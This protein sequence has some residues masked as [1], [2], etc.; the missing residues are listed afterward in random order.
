MTFFSIIIPTYNRAHLLPRCL[1]S[2]LAQSLADFEVIV[3]DDGS[4]DGTRTLVA[5]YAERDPRV[6]YAYQD[7][8][9][10]GDARNLGAS[11]AAGQWLTFLDS[12]DEVLPAWL[13]SF[14]AEID[15]QNPAVV[16]CGCEFVDED[17]RQHH[18]RLPVEPAGVPVHQWGF[19][20]TGTFAIRRELFQRLGGYASGLPAN[21]HSE[22]RL[23]LL[24]LCDR[25]GLCVACVQQPLVRRYTHGGP[26]IRSNVRAI[27]ESGVYILEHHGHVLRAVPRSFAAWATAIGTC[28][29]KLGD[30]G[31]ARL[32][33]R[34]SLVAWPLG[35]RNYARW[36]LAYLPGLRNACWRRHVDVPH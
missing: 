19:F 15:G 20:F 13:T 31:A 17:G 24:P 3:A 30:Y 2:V 11:L 4:T 5:E 29:A 8:R 23:R 34:K 9:G 25:E 18:T 1:D 36:A 22:L 14:A 33:F 28:A 10:A 7:N 12:D 35:W 16:C 26:N 27:Y 32:W 6:R 21:Q